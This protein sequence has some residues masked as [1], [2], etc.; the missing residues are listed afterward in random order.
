MSVLSVDVRLQ[1]EADTTYTIYIYIY[2]IHFASS[3]HG[4]L[5]WQLHQP[6]SIMA[7]QAV[8]DR[9]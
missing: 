7:V 9:I 5:C 3:F 1:T 8:D 6:V 2:S 4:A